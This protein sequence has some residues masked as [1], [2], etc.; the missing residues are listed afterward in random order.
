[1]PSRF[2]VV[3][4]RTLWLRTIFSVVILAATIAS[5]SQVPGPVNSLTF[6]VVGV[7]LVATLWVVKTTRVESIAWSIQRSRD[8]RMRQQARAHVAVR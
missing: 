2:A 1:M 3:A 7:G 8:A 6:F 4:R 5:V